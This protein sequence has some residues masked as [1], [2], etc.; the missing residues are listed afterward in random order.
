MPESVISAVTYLYNLTED[1][2]SAK[3]LQGKN[4]TEFFFSQS[5][6]HLNHSQHFKKQAK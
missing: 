1:I 3:A 4:L 5:K 2:V 6:F